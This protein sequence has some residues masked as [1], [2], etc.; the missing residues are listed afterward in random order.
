[1]D[2]SGPLGRRPGRDECF[3]LVWSSATFPG[4]GY[5]PRAPDIARAGYISR[6]PPLAVSTNMLSR[7]RIGVG[8]AGDLM[9]QAISA[10]FGFGCRRLHRP[11]HSL[12]VIPGH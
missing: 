12:L 1:M 10:L 4:D 2:G 11:D 5:Q 3:A 9:G 7:L 8:C 6:R